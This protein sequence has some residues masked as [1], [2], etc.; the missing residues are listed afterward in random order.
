[1][2]KSAI[3]ATGLLAATTTFQ[4]QA[5][6]AGE[7]FD[8]LASVM[9]SHDK[10]INAN[11][12]IDSNKKEAERYREKV[13]AGW[14]E[15]MQASSKA[16]PGEYCA[17]SFLRAK[18]RTE[19]GK[20]DKMKE[21][22]VVTLFGPGGNYRG[23]LLAFSPLGEDAADAFPRLANGKPVRVTLAQGNL[24]PVTLNAIYMQTSPKAPPLL[25][26]AVPNIEALMG[27]MQDNWTFDVS[28]EGKSIANIDWHD[29][30]KARDELKKCL[31]GKPF[32]NND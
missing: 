22:I 7:S 11:D 32:G 26:F 4:A 28:H 16:G 12:A 13:I 21:G 15:F 14:W 30:L 20:V 8:V 24:K 23:A 9:A 2:I 3:L 27:G 5:Q 18:R 10:E 25:A 1:M 19:P 17:A 29:G 31:A 6:V